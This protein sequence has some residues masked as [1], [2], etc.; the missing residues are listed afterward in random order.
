MS[1]SSTITDALATLRAQ[2]KILVE[3]LLVLE[4]QRER[5]VVEET[6]LVDCLR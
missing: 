3:T 4:D 5:L 6:D 1:M 2:E